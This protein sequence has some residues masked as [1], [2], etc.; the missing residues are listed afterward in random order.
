M[1]GFAVS[2]GVHDD[3]VQ[4]YLKNELDPPITQFDG[5]ERQVDGEGFAQYKFP[6]MSEEEF[7]SISE[8]LNG[9]DGVT[10]IG[11]DDQL[12][13]R[14]IMKLANLV[15]LKE[16]EHIPSDEEK[17]KLYPPG[18]NGFVELIDALV[19]TLETWQN[20]YV[21][22]FYTDEKNRADDYT[23]DIQELL[24]IYKDKAP[25]VKSGEMGDYDS[26]NLSEQK[27]RK[28]IRKTIRE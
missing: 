11:V 5:Y 18:E 20:R 8:F 23:I 27:L 12:T 13:E 10:L 22:G 4:S 17:P 9:T 26:K 21:G 25:K 14:K 1:F 19:K 7:R 15:P 6:D 2:V 28:L 3:R 16:W 24:E